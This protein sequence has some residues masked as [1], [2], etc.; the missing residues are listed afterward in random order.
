MNQVLNE[1]KFWNINWKCVSFGGITLNKGKKKKF[2]ESEKATVRPELKQKTEWPRQESETQ[3][4][5]YKNSNQ[6]SKIRKDHT[7]Y[8]YK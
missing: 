8:A 4:F 1:K 7:K 5:N 2:E 3:G 6:L